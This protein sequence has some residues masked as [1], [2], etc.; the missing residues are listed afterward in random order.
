MRGRGQAIDETRA[1]RHQVESPGPLGSDTILDQAGRAGEQHVGCDSANDDC[2]QVAGVDAAV[3]ERNAGSLDGH[4]GSGHFGRGD[5]AL[6]D[7]G[8]LDNPL[9]GGLD[10]PLQVL[11]GQNSG[12]R[13]AA[14]RS[15]LCLV[16]SRLGQL[17]PQLNNIQ[18]YNTA[19]SRCDRTHKSRA[20]HFYKEFTPVAT[21]SEKFW[22]T[23]NSLEVSICILT[24]SLFI[25]PAH[26]LWR[27]SR[28]RHL[29]RR[30]LFKPIW[31]PM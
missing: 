5:V 20:L 19:L 9:V 14:Q 10:H 2:I 31:S 3:I 6:H 7:A 25:A 11:V 26:L 24:R 27:Y 18:G 29:P 23:I 4:V 1:G 30:T 15:D 22:N 21:F 16:V 13:I 17:I 8:T 12:G 28:R